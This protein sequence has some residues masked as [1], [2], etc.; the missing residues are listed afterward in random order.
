MSAYHAF[1]AVYD[2]FMGEVDYEGWLRHIFALWEKFGLQPKTVIDLGCGTGSIALPLAKAGLDMTGVDLSAEM[3][4][5]A[6][7]KARA[8]GLSL[9][10]VCQDMTE[11]DLSEKADCILSLCDSMNYLT[12]E[13]QLE[14]AFQ[15]VAR[16]LQP[17]GLF[18]FDLNTEYQF[19]EVLGQ[20]IFASAEEDA[21]YIW[22]NTYDESEKINEYYVSFFI[23]QENGLYQRIEE[24]HY[25][26]AYSM[27][28]IEE[29][30]RVCGLE[31]AAVYDGYTFAQPGEESQRLLFVARWKT[32]R[33]E[34][35]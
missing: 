29:G 33:E 9:R 6:E 10:W 26:R 25:E 11:L 8:E 15:S 35:Q 32:E 4:A 18:I 5:E 14:Q 30:L 31:L 22:E 12:E 23:E 1:A 3:L 27:E 2:L 34:H 21:A 17:K 19:R 20:N 28:E 13:G 24:C 16:H 7:H